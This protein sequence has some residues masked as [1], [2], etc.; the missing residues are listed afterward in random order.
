MRV[1][2]QLSTLVRAGHSVDAHGKD[3]YLPHAAEHLKMPIHF[4]SGELNKV[5]YPA[6]T[7]K[8][9]MFLSE[10]NGPANYTRYVAPGYGHLDCIFG[11]NAHIDIFP[12]LAE[13]FLQHV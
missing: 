5:W 3:V 9:Y 10:K 6:S 13:F 4:L 7:E 8:T 11:K 12:R 1:F 2:T